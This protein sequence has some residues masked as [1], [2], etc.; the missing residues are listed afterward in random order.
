MLRVDLEQRHGYLYA[1]LSG[2]IDLSGAQA[3]YRQILQAAVSHGQPR[4]LMDCTRIAGEFST[5]D[6]LAFGSFMADEQ[7]RLASHLPEAPRV[8]ILAV[9]PL[10][11]PGRF[12]QT[13][14]N[15]RGVR[16]RASE[17]LQELVSWLGV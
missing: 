8:A 11:D 5:A 6:R 15:N 4:I 3:A 10:M 2:Q 13:V 17:S 7:Q 1:A 12:T 14:A 9:P 16:M